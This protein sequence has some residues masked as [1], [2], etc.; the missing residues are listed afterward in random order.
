MSSPDSQG[1]KATSATIDRCV[2]SFARRQLPPALP[3]ELSDLRG[4]GGIKG[5]FGARYREPRKLKRS[6]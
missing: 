3:I 4:G 2:R 1:Q 5:G 6:L